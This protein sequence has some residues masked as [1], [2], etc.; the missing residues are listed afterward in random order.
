MS[1]AC[2][3]HVLVRGSGSTCTCNVQCICSYTALLMKQ[4]LKGV[5]KHLPEPCQ[6]CWHFQMLL[7]LLPN[8]KNKM[9]V[10]SQ[11]WLV[12]ACLPASKINTLSKKCNINC[13]YSF[14]KLEIYTLHINVS[15][16][17]D[18]CIFWHGHWTWNLSLVNGYFNILM[19]ER[20]LVI[21]FGN[22]LVLVGKWNAFENWRKFPLSTQLFSKHRGF[23]H[24]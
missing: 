13:L 22:R 24:T 20:R 4:W 10:S 5:L 7:Q 18:P 19:F 9:S 14:P 2:L 12:T 16:L 23:H 6:G 17:T 11:R 3:V 1:H 15:V 8:S 21:P